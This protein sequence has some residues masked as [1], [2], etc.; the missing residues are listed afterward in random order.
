[1]QAD[2]LPDYLH[3]TELIEEVKVPLW[4]ELF[5]QCGFPPPLKEADLEKEKGAHDRIAEVVFRQKLD[6]KLSDAIE[7]IEELGSEI[8]RDVLMG[9]IDDAGI[10]R[11]SW[12]TDHGARELALYVWMRRFAD[13]RLVDA[14]D[15]ARVRMFE[16]GT[17]RPLFEFAGKSAK[18]I[19]VEEKA[20]RAT[21]QEA[22]SAWCKAND[23]GE[24]TEVKVYLRDANAV[25]QIIHGEPFKNQMTVTD[26]GRS[27][28]RF[29][30]G[31]SDLVRYDA[32]EGR[33][34]IAARSG[35]LVAAYREMFGRALFG[36]PEFFKEDAKCTLRPLQDKG[37]DA[38][39]E[40]PPLVSSLHV[41]ELTWHPGGATSHR[42][43]ADDCFQEIDRLE[44]PIT[45]GELSEAK[46]EFKI[47]DGKRLHRKVVTIR[48]P[49]RVSN[50]H[51]RYAERIDKFLFRVG[52]RLRGK[53]DGASNLW[54]LYPWRHSE[55]RWREALGAQAAFFIREGL[56]RAEALDTVGN[57]DVSS[58]VHD[59]RVR[60]RG[61]G[62][63]DG[64]SQV[65]GVPSRK[66]SPT[67]VSG[68]ELDV[69]ALARRVG[70]TV[71]CTSPVKAVTGVPGTF[72]LGDREFGRHRVR[73]FFLARRPPAALKDL[74]DRLTRIAGRARAVVIAPAG[75]RADCGLPE[76]ELGIGTDPLSDAL[77]TAISAA[78]LEKDAP[79]IEQADEGARMIFDAREGTIHLDGFMLS[80]IDGR[81]KPFKFLLALAHAKGEIVS[82]LHLSNKILGGAVDGPKD[83]ARRARDAIRLSFK[84]ASRAEPADLKDLIVCEKGGY[85]LR[86]TVYVKP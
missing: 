13:E 46:L 2:Y 9:A 86:T 55:T 35:K 60:H 78:G 66:L 34:R 39:G 37:A 51:D 56:M 23:R 68:L 58:G 10:S 33:I 84:K 4:R 30:P 22:A 20:I 85:A 25:F 79:A 3:K 11:V 52:I 18:P 72:D 71:G 36:D 12:P 16:M 6:L 59:L 32:F 14:L 7:T 61:D 80:S 81:S 83:A 28:V 45:E 41:T 47:I 54:A 44:L 40:L 74:S 57:S 8:G 24:Y 64:V 1:M 82:S 53:L 75:C 67:E 62:D 5:A 31:L 73:F 42:I 48:T 17:Q 50:R 29:R 43:S 63:I 65:D 38:F 21:V 76:V 27:N 15:A 49:N 26:R 70:D 19:Q 77:R 69:H